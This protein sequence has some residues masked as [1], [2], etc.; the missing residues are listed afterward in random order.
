MATH[1]RHHPKFGKMLRDIKIGRIKNGKT[2]EIM[3]DKRLTLAISRVPDLPKLLIDS[4][5]GED[6]DLRKNVRK[7]K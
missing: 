4:D 7:K 2:D 1:I 3:T 6:I 5:F